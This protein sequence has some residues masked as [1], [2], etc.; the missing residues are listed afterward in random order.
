MSAATVVRSQADPG[1]ASTAVAKPEPFTFVIF[2]ATGDLAARK[3]LPALYGLWHGH[4]LP[5]DFAIVGVGRRDK[6][7]DAFRQ[8]VEKALKKFRKDWP[9]AGHGQENLLANVFYHR[10]DFNQPGAMQGLR[11]R[12]KSGG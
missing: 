7:D 8:D 4:F 11:P 2:G 3:L 10:A 6:S 5:E 12:P 1:H 9:P